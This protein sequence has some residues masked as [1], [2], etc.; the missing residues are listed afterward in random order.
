MA[1]T[2]VE[3]PAADFEARLQ[4]AGFTR[5]IQGSEVVYRR[6]HARCQHLSVKIYTSLPANGGD[7]RACGSD[8]IRVVAVFEKAGTEA[9]RAISFAIYKGKRVHRA[10]SIEAVLTRTIDRAREAYAAC[11]EFCKGDRRCWT[12]CG[13][14]PSIASHNH[15]N[16]NTIAGAA[17]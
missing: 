10:G 15:A 7:V 4:A 14:P 2:Y 8:A 11:N 6:V 1:A 13:K 5:E 9:R 16:A 17:S 12:C 3:V